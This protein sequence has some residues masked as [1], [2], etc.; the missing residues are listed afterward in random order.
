MRNT[1]MNVTPFYPALLLAAAALLAGC[2][3]AQSDF[4]CGATAGDTCMTMEA[5][6]DRA[7][8]LAAPVKPAAGALPR[9]ADRQAAV[10]AALPAVKPAPAVS[11]TVT[12][13]AKPAPAVSV[14]VTPAA[15]PV[16]R[17]LLRPAAAPLLPA[18]A[19]VPAA[20]AT[21]G[22]VPAVRT[23]AVTAGVW[24]APYVDDGGVLHQPGR[25]SFVAV[26]SRWRL[27]AGGE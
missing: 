27:P 4:E 19:H 3:G 26:P 10:P 16:G 18:S 6:N 15:T 11:V 17:G 2:A 24:V 1:G 5:A 9:L 13:A 20:C 23:V 8:A 7:R 12:P 25:L 21:C 22:G 14:I